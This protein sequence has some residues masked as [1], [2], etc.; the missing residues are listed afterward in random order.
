MTWKKS[1]FLKGTL[2]H[3][4]L[5]KLDDLKTFRGGQITWYGV[6]SLQM[7]QATNADTAKKHGKASSHS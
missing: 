4:T 2:K 5:V 6:W 3:F 7:L 1:R